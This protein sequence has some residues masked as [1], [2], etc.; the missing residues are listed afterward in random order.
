[1][2]LQ[3]IQT[4]N[5]D[6]NMEMGPSGR[7]YLRVYKQMDRKSIKGKEY[8]VAPYRVA[9][10]MEYQSKID[11]LVFK[12]G[13]NADTNRKYIEWGSFLHSNTTCGPEISAMYPPGY[14][15]YLCSKLPKH[16][17]WEI[18]TACVPL[19]SVVTTGLQDDMP[20]IVSRIIILPGYPQK[21]ISVA[22]ADRLYVEYMR[23]NKQDYTQKGQRHVVYY[24]PK[25]T[26]GC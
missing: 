21:Y 5:I 6:N 16:L 24:F 26:G 10:L 7:Y 4:V 22:A 3:T 25:N 13:V 11:H 12:P 19:M 2:C 17:Y 15:S 20:A 9:T 14:H 23:Q 1:M 8:W 18:I